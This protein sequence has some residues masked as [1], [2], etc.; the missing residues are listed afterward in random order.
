M[1]HFVGRPWTHVALDAW[2]RTRQSVRCGLAENLI[3]FWVTDKLGTGESV[4]FLKKKKENLSGL[5][6]V[7]WQFCGETLHLVPVSNEVKKNRTWP[8]IDR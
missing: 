1:D 2:G 6:L 7:L 4:R 5:L 3:C 8:E